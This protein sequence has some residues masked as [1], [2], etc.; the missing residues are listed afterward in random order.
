MLLWQVSGGYKKGYH[1]GRDLCPLC[2]I[3][4]YFDHDLRN[5]EEYLNHNQSI[6]LKLKDYAFKLYTFLMECYHVDKIS[7]EIFSRHYCGRVVTDTQVKKWTHFEQNSQ[8][9]YQT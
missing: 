3:K 1:M 2:C 7:L 4:I 6:L 9:K 8:G 5:F